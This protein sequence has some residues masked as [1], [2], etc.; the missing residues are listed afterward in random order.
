MTTRCFSLT[1]LSILAAAC[2]LALSAGT[3]IAHD[4]PGQRMMGMGQHQP[5]D[6]IV[7]LLKLEGAKADQVRAIM[8]ES[9]AERRA[10][11]ASM[12]DK[13]DDP[14]ARKAARAQMRAIHE[15]TKTKLAKVLTAEEMK[16]LED[17]R[18]ERRGHGPH[19][20][21]GPKHG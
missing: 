8:K 12:K 7:E 13:K 6:R 9:F 18:G 5:G 15:N 10:I 11:R 4:G 20:D 16:K 17:F 19:G 2:G 1:K 14:E 21:K 3:A